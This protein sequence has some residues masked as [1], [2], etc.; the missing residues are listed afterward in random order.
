MNNEHRRQ[1]VNFVFDFLSDFVDDAKSEE[2]GGET[3]PSLSLMGS[4]ADCGG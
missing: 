3:G 1:W 2:T 4:I